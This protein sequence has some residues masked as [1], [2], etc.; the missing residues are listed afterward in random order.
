MESDYVLLCP[1]DAVST[2]S[3]SLSL[4]KLPGDEEGVVGQAT[5]NLCPALSFGLLE[6]SLCLQKGTLGQAFRKD[7][8]MLQDRAKRACPGIIRGHQTFGKPQNGKDK[9]IRQ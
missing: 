1:G 5:G 6:C 2:T 9:C 8:G 7:R 4:A 3:L